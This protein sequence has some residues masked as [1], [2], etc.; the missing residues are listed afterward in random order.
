MPDQQLTD[1]FGAPVTE[2]P[3]ALKTLKP[4]KAAADLC[5]LVKVERIAEMPLNRAKVETPADIWSF[6]TSMVSPLPIHDANKEWL[7]VVLLDTKLKPIAFN[8]VSCGSVNES[9]AHPREVFRLT[10][11]L[12]AYG[13]V[14]THNHPS[15]DP[16]PSEADR[17]L[18]QRLRSGAE[19]LN[20]AFL[21]HVVIGSTEGGRTPWFSFREAGLL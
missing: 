17:R 13:F 8:M 7:Y 11:A 3:K 20:I 5:A 19:L 2:K 21:D 6:W 9:L 1:L 10:I 4:Y 18:T 12:G 14:L 15:G 16:T